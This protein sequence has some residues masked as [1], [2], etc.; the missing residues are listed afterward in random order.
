MYKPSETSWLPTS[1]TVE[2]Q[3]CFLSARISKIRERNGEAVRPSVKALGQEC[4]S[5]LLLVRMRFW[6]N[7]EKMGKD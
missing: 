3:T 4:A 6:D 7:L 2:E 1:R 5:H